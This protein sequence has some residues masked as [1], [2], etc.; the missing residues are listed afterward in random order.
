MDKE[1]FGGFQSNK[2]LQIYLEFTGK[3]LELMQQE[4]MNKILGNNVVPID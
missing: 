2:Q 4:I 1:N 3:A